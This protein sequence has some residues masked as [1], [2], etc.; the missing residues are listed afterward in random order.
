MLIEP[1]LLVRK[2]ELPAAT[3]PVHRRP[4]PASQAMDQHP[5]SGLSLRYHRE[6]RDMARPLSRK[7]ACWRR[8]H[9]HN[10]RSIPHIFRMN[11]TRRQRPRFIQRPHRVRKKIGHRNSVDGFC[12]M[13]CK[14]AQHMS[15][16]SA[17]GQN[18]PNR[19]D[20]ARRAGGRPHS[21]SLRIGLHETKN[22]VLIRT[23]PCGDRIPQHRRKNGTQ[24]RQ[25]SDHALVDEGVQ[26]RH[27][28]LIQQR[29]N[30]LP[31]SRIPADQENFFRGMFTH[32]AVPTP[33]Q[34][35]T[36]SRVYYTLLG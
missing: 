34:M 14:P 2:L 31:I 26:S 27:Q 22:S 25:V 23:F 12:Q 1:Q 3:A 24:S 36:G 15:F 18:V 4:M 6:E 35:P 13:P 9:K 10:S 28:P 20:L 30:Q 32:K 29:I 19:L 7:S 33:R 5:H 8:F 11:R 17:L 21:A 16:V